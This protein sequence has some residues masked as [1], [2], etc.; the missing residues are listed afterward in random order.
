MKLAKDYAEKG[1]MVDYELDVKHDMFVPTQM[2]AETAE[3]I[4]KRAKKIE[5]AEKDGVP[6]LVVDEDQWFPAEV[7]EVEETDKIGTYKPSTPKKSGRPTKA[8]LVEE[9][10]ETMTNPQLYRAINEAK[11]ENEEKR[12]AKAVK[13]D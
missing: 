7:F 10:R 8:E 3:E 9:A 11:Q 4:V 13:K 12:A 1:L 2:P 5:R 6:M